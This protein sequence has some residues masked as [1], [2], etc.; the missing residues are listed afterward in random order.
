MEMFWVPAVAVAAT[1]TVTVALTPEASD[2]GLMVTVIP[3]GALAVRATVFLA[4]PF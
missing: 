4:V 3:V 2:A 1:A